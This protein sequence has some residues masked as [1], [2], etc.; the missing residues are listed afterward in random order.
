MP[1]DPNIALSYRPPKFESPVNQMAGVLE[2]Q[3]AQQSNQ[4]NALGL[5]ERQR[6]V[7]DNNR[8]RDLYAQPDF[9][10]NT[11]EGIRRVGQVLPARATELQK[12]RQDRLKTQGEIDAKAFETASKRFGAY[13]QTMGSLSKA[14]NL[15][16]D[17][18]VRAGRQMVQL[19]VM[20]QAMFDDG[21][22]DL[23]ED[24]VQLR[25]ALEDDLRTQLTPEQMFSVFAPKVAT[26][27]NG[28]QIFRVDDNP[29][30]PTFGKRIG[31]PA[32]QK[33]QSPESRASQA[34]AIRG[35]NMADARSK[36][37]N[38]LKARELDA[39][40]QPSNAPVLGA[41]VPTVLP[42]ANQSNPKDANK[43]KANELA[44]GSKE[45]E[46]DID[47]AKKEADAAAAAKRFLELNKGTNTGA[48][49]D[50]IGMTRGL[51]SL[52]SDYAEMESITAKLAPS[53]R[54]EGSGSTSDFDGKQ[55]ERATV[56]VD[57]PGTTNRNIAQGVIARAQNSQEYA[58]FRQTYLEQNGTLQG[59]DRFWKDYSNKNPIFDPEKEGTFALNP[60]RKTWREHFQGGNPAAPS[61]EGLSAAEAAE[62]ADL[63]K[64][65]GSRRDGE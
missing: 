48:L 8:L 9:D 51:Q 17:M 33:R 49:V 1:I 6:A 27:D 29:N 30:S 39:Q 23:P 47:F 42:W 38:A 55:F 31:A 59:A 18:V 14:P 60:S 2:L 24:P 22:A 20:P 57:K 19:G 45:I 58:D 35:Q 54:A 65:V 44:R 10:E 34:T 32:E 12:A 43:V 37:A 4:L 16:R 36:E 5:Q 63:R 56:G 46:K 21:I 11:D 53:M 3:N 15:T 41:P 28:Q 25:A 26:V 50:R 64:R 62:L 7:E 52:G 13:K 40:G 61:G